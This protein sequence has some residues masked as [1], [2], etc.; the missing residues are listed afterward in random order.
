MRGLL[1]YGHVVL[2]GPLVAAL[3]VARFEANLLDAVEVDG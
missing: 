1:A 2:I 3:G